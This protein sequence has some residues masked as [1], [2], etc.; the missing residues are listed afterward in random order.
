[1]ISKDNINKFKNILS[2]ATD[3]NLIKHLQEK[4]E[5]LEKNKTILK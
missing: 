3:D 5:I 2:K 4:I 1:M